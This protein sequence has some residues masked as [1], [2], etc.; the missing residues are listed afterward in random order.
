MF[1]G[2]ALL[3]RRLA[4]QENLLVGAPFECDPRKTNDF[5]PNN[6]DSFL[7]KNI[8]IREVEAKFYDYLH[9][10]T[11]CKT[12]GKLGTFNGGTRKSENDYYGNGS[13]PREAFGNAQAEFCALICLKL[14]GL[15]KFF[16][17]ENPF[18]SMLFDFPPIKALLK[19]L[20]NILNRPLHICSAI[21]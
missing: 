12:W 7:V 5:D 16:S 3:S 17:I 14:L 18:G 21:R 11:P 9:M 10:G 6:L 13:L 4:S 8:M 2:F 15:G 20:E 1:G 19:H